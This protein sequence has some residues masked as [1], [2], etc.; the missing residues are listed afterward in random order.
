[1]PIFQVERT[2]TKLAN[3]DSFNPG[4]PVPIIGQKPSKIRGNKPKQTITNRKYDAST[5]R[6]RSGHIQPSPTKSNL[7]T[8]PQSASISEG[9]KWNKVQPSAR[10]QIRHPAPRAMPHPNPLWPHGNKPQTHQKRPFSKWNRPEPST[11]IPITMYPRQT[12][13]PRQ[14]RSNPFLR[15]SASSASLRLSP[16]LHQT[17]EPSKTPEIR[18]NQTISNL[19]NWVCTFT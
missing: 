2:R 9:T 15:V 19:S 13:S 3:P 5:L 18:V 10:K 1:M 6:P 8:G 12:P 7:S 4:Y 11:K 14:T 17:L 16:S